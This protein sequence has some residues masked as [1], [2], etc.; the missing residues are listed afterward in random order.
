MTEDV[1]ALL[2]AY[3][4]WR[5]ATLARLRAIIR[6]ADARIDESIKWRKPSNPLGVLA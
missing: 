2:A 6:G 1:Q 5:S 4:D 3:P